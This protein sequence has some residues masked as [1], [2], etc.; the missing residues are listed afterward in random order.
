MI[1]ADRVNFLKCQGESIKQ[2]IDSEKINKGDKTL[3]TL[4]KTK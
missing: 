3:I 1:T 2:K 4:S